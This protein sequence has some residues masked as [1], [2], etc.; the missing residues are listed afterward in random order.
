MLRLIGI[1]LNPKK[2]MT[3][4]ALEKINDSDEIYLELYT[5]RIVDMTLDELENLINRKITLLDRKTIESEFLVERSRKMNVSLLVPGDPIIATTHI[6]L[7]ISSI[8]NNVEY[9]IING[10]SVQCVV[11]SILGLQNYKFGRSVSIPF[12]E[13]DYYPESVYNFVLE[14]RKLGL[15]T[16]VFLDLRESLEMSALMGIDILLKMESMYR[17][18][19]IDK[20]TIIAVISKAGSEKQ[21]AIADKIERIKER[22]L[23]PTPHIMVII[24][25]LHY[26]ELEALKKL[27]SFP[28]NEN[29]NLL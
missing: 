15:H 20:N 17:K 1:G 14:N 4:E 8:Q 25:S 18:D 9:E 28:E 24:G 10:I 3:L 13:Y 2:H 19:A 5:S 23:G 7:V 29:I 12:P 11:P 27:A 16:L 21:R 6:G 26:M 22:D